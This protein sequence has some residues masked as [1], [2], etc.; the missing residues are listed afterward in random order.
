MTGARCCCRPLFGRLE[1]QTAR[2]PAGSEASCVMTRREPTREEGSELN[3]RG[4][5]ETRTEAG[6]LETTK[7]P[8]VRNLPT[9]RLGAAEFWTSASCLHATHRCGPNDWG[10]TM[11]AFGWK[12]GMFLAAR[13]SSQT[14]DAVPLPDA[15]REFVRGNRDVW[16][17]TRCARRAMAGGG[18]RG[19]A[20]RIEGD[21]RHRTV[22][23]S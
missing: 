8:A 10:L 6:Q 16:T 21:L 15:G 17:G 4:T 3:T 14:G 12:P 18:N 9:W 7:R 5:C 23:G 11:K 20:L 13:F 22:Q 1:L 19:R 2:L